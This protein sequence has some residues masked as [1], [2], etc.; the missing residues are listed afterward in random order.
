MIWSDVRD[1]TADCLQGFDAGHMTADD[2]G[3]R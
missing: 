2:N 1:V 3:H